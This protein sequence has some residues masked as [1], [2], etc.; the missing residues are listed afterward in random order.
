MNAPAVIVPP[1]SE[2]HRIAIHDA[3]AWRGRCINLFARAERVVTNSLPG[4]SKPKAPLLGQ[5]LDMLA[6]AM[7]DRAEVLASINAFKELT[8]LRN[9]IVHREGRVFSD[10]KGGWLLQF[11]ATPGND[12]LRVSDL[13]A[14][15]LRRQIQ[16]AV[17]KL[18]SNLD[19]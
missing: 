3:N 9:A 19:A 4:A 10:A 11:E 16:R 2:W 1:L 7:S 14:E 17:D 8:E 5:K 12:C 6:K 18:A 15:E 13:E